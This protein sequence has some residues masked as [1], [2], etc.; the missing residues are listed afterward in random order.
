[1]DPENPPVG[2]NRSGLYY[3]SDAHIQRAIY[4]L[5]TV[6]SSLTPMV[7][8]IALYFVRHLGARLGLVCAFTLMFALCLALATRARRIE[9]FA[10]TAA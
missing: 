5:G 4:I 6:A 10:A 3:Y 1:V 2:E 9:I 7:S 8:I